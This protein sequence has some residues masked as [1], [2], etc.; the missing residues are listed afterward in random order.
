MPQRILWQAATYIMAAAT[1]LM[2]EAHDRTP[3]APPDNI[4]GHGA[5]DVKADR[6]Y[7]L[8]TKLCL[9]NRHPRLLPC[10]AREHR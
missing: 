10:T 9:A 1:H 4:L 7:A 2:E 6:V 8:R 3:L 5:V